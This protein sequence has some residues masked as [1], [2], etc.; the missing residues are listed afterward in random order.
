M[1]NEPESGSRRIRSSERQPFEFTPGDSLDTPADS[2]VAT[3]DGEGV[4]RRLTRAGLV[5]K[6]Q[7]LE[8]AAAL[9]AENGYE[10]TRVVDIMR[11]AGVS[12]GLFYWYFE[13]KEALFRELVIS[14]RRSLR[15]AQS[16]AA[17][18]EVDPLRRLALAIAASVEFVASNY[19]LYT[20]ITRTSVRERF[21]ELMFD[22]A[23]YYTAETARAIAGC[24]EAGIAR[25]GDPVEMAAGINGAV[26]AFATLGVTRQSE[27]SSAENSVHC[28]EF[29]IRS[30]AADLDTVDDVMTVVRDRSALLT[31]SAATESAQI[32]EVVATH[33]TSP[34]SG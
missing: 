15:A 4:E 32:S 24:Q 22:G 26:S 31:A 19:N 28:T 2:L 33:A 12:K 17:T 29:C 25:E 6:A 7:L 3:V 1:E 11:A 21:G 18:D 16:A 20:L 27:T 23:S 8:K 30:I 13:N 9:F 34:E 10:E 5:R 14:T